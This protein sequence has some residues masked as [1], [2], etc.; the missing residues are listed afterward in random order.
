MATPARRPSDGPLLGRR[1]P[2]LCLDWLACYAI[3][4]GFFDANEWVTL[5]IFAIENLLLVSTLG[6][7][8]GH[9]LL[10]L[11]VVRDDG[12]A[13]VGVPK[14][15]GRTALLCLVIPAVVWDEEGRGMH[16]RLVGTRIVRT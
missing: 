3:S 12:A 4:A 9:R 13:F 16:D 11:R 1:I 8:L 10:G 6:T 5:G 2:A 15:L 14:A 7:T